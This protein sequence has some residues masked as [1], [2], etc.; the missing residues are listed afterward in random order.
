M[1]LGHQEAVQKVIRGRE[2]ERIRRFERSDVERILHHWIV[3]LFVCK[4][5]HF[6]PDQRKSAYGSKMRFGVARRKDVVENCEHRVFPVALGM[7]L[8]RNSKLIFV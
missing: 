5:L 3:S 2:V 7:S 6:G 1:Q 4:G 8:D